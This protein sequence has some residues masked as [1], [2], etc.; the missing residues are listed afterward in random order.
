MILLCVLVASSALCADD[1]S[2]WY[3]FTA[4]GGLSR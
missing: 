4:K 1:V 2:D 3:S